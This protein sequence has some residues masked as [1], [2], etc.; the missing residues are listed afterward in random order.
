MLL[1]GRPLFT[2]L[3]AFVFCGT[4][5]AALWN[6]KMPLNIQTHILYIRNELFIFIA[7]SPAPHLFISCIYSIFHRYFHNL[8]VKIITVFL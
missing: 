5:P 1:F 3:S 7:N 6:N 8:S 2:F 4:A